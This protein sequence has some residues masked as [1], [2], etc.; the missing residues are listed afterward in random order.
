MIAVLVVASLIL[1][2]LYALLRPL[3]SAWL[4]TQPRRVRPADRTPAD[5]G[6]AYEDVTLSSDGGHLRGWYVPSRNGAAVVLLHDHGANRL[7]LAPHAAM[8]TRAGYGVLLLDLRAHGRS[9][10]RR[11]NRG[12]AV[13]D[14]LAAVAWVA[15][16]HDVQA[17]VAVLGV[18][19]GGT[20]ALHAAARNA[21][22]R[23]A[24]ADGPLPGALP[25]LP[26]PSGV[27]DRLWRYPQAYLFHAALERLAPD[28]RLPANAH[29]LNRLG[30]RPLLLISAGKRREHRLTR[31]LFAAAD[32]PK[33]LYEIPD[34]AHATGWAVAPEEYDQQLLAFFGRALSVEYRPEAATKHTAPPMGNAPHP[35]AG[36]A[37][38]AVGERTVAPAAAMMLSF[39]AVPVS[40]LALFVPYQLRWGL[41]PPRLPAGRPVA[42][43]LGFFGLLLAGLLL[44]EAV[45]LLG[46]RLFGHTPRGMAR[47]HFGRA[48]L[49][50]QV[51]CDA[52]IRA[53][54]YRRVLLLPA[55][56]LGVIPA[57]AAL[58]F[59]SWWALVWATWMLAASG[60]DFAALWAMRG[61]ATDAPV[62]AHPRRAGC[63]IFASVDIVQNI[64]K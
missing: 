5:W 62:R 64:D 18:G 21:F 59:G 30:G 35:A 7:A 10:G 3:L 45:H 4:F 40:L 63:Q 34:A 47:F 52:P 24:A 28:P 50:P 26:P 13:D 43:L 39:A 61:V 31:H 9:D 27:A 32:E 11:F 8:L 36:P 48:A 29:A 23:G 57:V 37:P 20:L 15:R 16:R 33:T 14:A 41:A 60:G 2:L 42:A 49:T 58:L 17:R 54:A 51:Q 6:A 12:A 46:Y 44:H 55:L 38:Q 53:A 25:D 22:I 1:L 56:L 19:L